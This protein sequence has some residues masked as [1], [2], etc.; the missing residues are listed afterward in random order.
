V[1]AKQVPTAMSLHNNRGTAENGVFYMVC[2]KG[3]YN[4]DT[5]PAVVSCKGVC[6]EKTRRLV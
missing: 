1:A 2:A 5:S 6:E 4:E 3:L